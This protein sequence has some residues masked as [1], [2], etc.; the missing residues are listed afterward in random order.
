MFFLLGYAPLMERRQ[1]SGL[2]DPRGQGLRNG[3][4][5]IDD[6]S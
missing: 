6:S 4:H 5:F 1:G 3:V 2:L